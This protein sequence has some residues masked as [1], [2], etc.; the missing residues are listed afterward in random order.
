MFNDFIDFY[1]I[2]DSDEVRYVWYW[3]NTYNKMQAL[4]AINGKPVRI[5]E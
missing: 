5:D 1:G 3:N 2:M 4:V